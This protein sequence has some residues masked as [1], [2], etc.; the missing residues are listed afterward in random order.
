MEIKISCETSKHQNTLLFTHRN[1]SAG[2][3]ASFFK[4]RDQE[5][6]AFFKNRSQEIIAFYYEFIFHYQSKLRES[7]L[8]WLWWK[9][10]MDTLFVPYN[11]FYS[12]ERFWNT[13]NK[14][15][16]I[17]LKRCYLLWRR[18][19]IIIFP[20]ILFRHVQ[21]IHWSFSLSKKK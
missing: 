5:I 17:L 18:S 15:R 12:Y 21:V 4:S 2:Q 3:S 7:W 16:F 20:H 6:F 19:A 8:R 10:L 14:M 1:F 11:W 13:H 9:W